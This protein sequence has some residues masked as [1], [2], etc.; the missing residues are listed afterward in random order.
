MTVHPL[1]EHEMKTLT[2]PQKRC[3]QSIR[4]AGAHSQIFHTCHLPVLES[5]QDLGLIDLTV[6]TDEHTPA[7][8]IKGY[9]LWATCTEYKV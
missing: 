6:G 5:L 8:G 3:L 2:P 7:N 4:R 9:T 1:T